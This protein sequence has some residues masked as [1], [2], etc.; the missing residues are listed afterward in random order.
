ME[1]GMRDNWSIIVDKDD[2]QRLLS[3]KIIHELSREAEFNLALRQL[4]AKKSARERESM[5]KE[6]KR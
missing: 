2:M 6:N 4:A 1:R 5:T 3:R